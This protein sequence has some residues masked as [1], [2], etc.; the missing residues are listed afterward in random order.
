M[1]TYWKPRFQNNYIGRVFPPPPLLLTPQTAG[2]YYF[3]RG[4]DFVSGAKAMIKKKITTNGIYFVCPV[5]NEL[6]NRGLKIRKYDIEKVWTF[7]VPEELDY[8][9]K[10]FK[11]V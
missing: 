7:A 1:R 6:I 2:V 5:Y 8:F 11:A 9:A 3:R 4:Q 10:N